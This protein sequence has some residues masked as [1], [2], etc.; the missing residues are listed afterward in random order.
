MQG[1]KKKTGEKLTWVDTSQEECKTPA[2][3]WQIWD[4]GKILLLGLCPYSCFP[5]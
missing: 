5:Y 4:K 2:P 1:W 3:C